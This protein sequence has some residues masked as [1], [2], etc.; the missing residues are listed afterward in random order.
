MVHYVGGGCIPGG[1]PASWASSRLPDPISALKRPLTSHLDGE[2]GLG[3]VA[4]AD[5]MVV[6]WPHIMCCIVGH[7][8]VA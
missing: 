4:V 3:E 5:D 1:Y 2:E 6:W 8:G 7:D